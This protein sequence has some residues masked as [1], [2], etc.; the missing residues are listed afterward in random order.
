MVWLLLKKTKRQDYSLLIFAPLF[1]CVCACVCFCSGPAGAEAAVNCRTY[2]LLL[3]NMPKYDA[4]GPYRTVEWV[5]WVMRAIVL[6][7]MVR[8]VAVHRVSA[9]WWTH[10]MREQ[11]RVCV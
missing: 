4:G 6:A 7:K 8:H 11:L 3:P 2:R 10:M 1:A 5:R 9:V